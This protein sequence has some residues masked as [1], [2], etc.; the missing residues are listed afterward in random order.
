MDKCT[1]LSGSHHDSENEIA[2]RL[3]GNGVSRKKFVI[4]GD[5]LY[6]EVET[7]LDAS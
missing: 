3:K 6:S 5:D 7:N 2:S 1:L 4:E